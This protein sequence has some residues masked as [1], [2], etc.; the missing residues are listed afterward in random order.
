MIISHSV[1]MAFLFS[2]D[3]QQISIWYA[4][5]HRA[6]TGQHSYNENSQKNRTTGYGWHKSPESMP[7]L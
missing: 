3:T 7:Y 2:D 5:E 6:E 1:T 4:N